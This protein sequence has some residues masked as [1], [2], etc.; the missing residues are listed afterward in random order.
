MA[1]PKK[2]T[3]RIVV[4]ATAYRWRVRSRPTYCQGNAWGNLSFAVE[5]EDAGQTTLVVEVD[6]SRPDNWVG[7]PSAV[8][9]PA[10]VERAIRNALQRGW[11]PHERGSPHPLSLSVVVST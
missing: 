6:A 3:R 9:T 5:L 1:I 10:I 7:A 8:I 11:R 2:G 4:D